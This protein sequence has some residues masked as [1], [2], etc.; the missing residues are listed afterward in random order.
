MALL[1][2]HRPHRGRR[3]GAPPLQAL[4]RARGSPQRRAGA[5]AGPRPHR[6]GAQPRARLQLL[7][8]ATQAPMQQQ[9]VQ[10]RSMQ[11]SSGGCAFLPGCIQGQ[12]SVWVDDK[13]CF[14]AKA[15][16]TFLSDRLCGGSPPVL[17]LLCECPPHTHA[18]AVG[19]KRPSSQRRA[20]EAS[21]DVAA[22]AAPSASR[23]AMAGTSPAAKKP[24]ARPHIAFGRRL[25]SPPRRSRSRSR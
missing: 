22:A 7:G 14:L 25:D 9:A 6:A 2:P 8:V 5:V 4:S 18:G 15:L 20:G 11:V 16:P 17:C 1:L 19:H 13:V 23:E 3:A 21:A 24:K 10:G 12:R